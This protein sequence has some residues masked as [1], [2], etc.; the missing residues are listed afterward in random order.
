[1]GGARLT[2]HTDS[3]T[4]SNRNAPARA[5]GRKIL[6]P[7]I[8]SMGA[9]WLLNAVLPIP[10]TGEEAAPQAQEDAAGKHGP[11]P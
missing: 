6:R 9:S 4:P 2:G 3:N 10:A 11:Q 5:R 8:L 7:A 1:M